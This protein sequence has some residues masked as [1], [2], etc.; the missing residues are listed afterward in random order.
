M[1][2]TL[3]IRQRAAVDVCVDG[4]TDL[5][6]FQ[7]FCLAFDTEDEYRSTSWR[8]LPQK[9]KKKMERRPATVLSMNM[10]GK[11]SSHECDHFPKCN[12]SMLNKSP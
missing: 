10:N 12:G 9:N 5:H 4:F 2:A 3:T 8:P 6:F 1:T 11:C 7:R